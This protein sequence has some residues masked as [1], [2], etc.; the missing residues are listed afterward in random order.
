MYAK[1]GILLHKDIELKFIEL[2][3]DWIIHQCKIQNKIQR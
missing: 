2:M 3:Q 1:N